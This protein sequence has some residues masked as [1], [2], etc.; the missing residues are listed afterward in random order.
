MVYLTPTLPSRY[1]WMLRGPAQCLKRKSC[2]FQHQLSIRFIESNNDDD[3]DDDDEEE[4]E[5][6]EEED[7]ED[8]NDDIDDATLF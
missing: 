6:E 8:D 3:D 7:E 4:E 1:C 2:F 5:E